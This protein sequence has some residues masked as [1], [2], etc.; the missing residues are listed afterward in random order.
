MRDQRLTR[1]HKSSKTRSSNRVDSPGRLMFGWGARLLAAVGAGAMGISLVFAQTPGPLSVSGTGGN[2]QQVSTPILG[3]GG[4][5]TY[6]QGAYRVHVFTSNGTFTPPQGLTQLDVLIVG[7]GGGGGST[8][9]GGGGAGGLRWETNVTVNQPS[10]SVVVGAGGAGGAGISSTNDPSGNGQA[11]QNSSFGT[12]I[13][14][15]GG[16]GQ[17]GAQSS[18][19][20]GSGGSGGGGGGITGGSARPGGSA[21]AGQGNVGGAGNGTSSASNRSGGGGGG[22]GAAGSVGTDGSGGNGG[23]GQNFSTQFGTGVGA[24]GWF[25]GGGGGGK[26]SGGGSGGTGGTGGGGAGGSP[27][28]NSGVAGQAN[29]GGGGGASGGTG[30]VPG[31]AGGSGVVIVRY[32]PPTNNFTVHTFNSSGTFVPPPG[33]SSVDVLVVAG[34]GGGGTSQAFGDAGAGGGGAGGLVYRTGFA[35][36]S[37]VA[38][39]VGAGGTAGVGPGHQTG[40]N[41]GNS[42]FGSLTALGGGGGFGGNGQGN[43]GGS[44]GGSRG[45]NGGAATQPGAAT[46]GSGSAGGNSGGSPAGAAATGGGGAGGAGQNLA[47]TTGEA[48][49]NGGVGLSYNISGTATFYA[50]G[51]GGGAAQNRAAGGTGGNGGGGN[52]G[53]NT[54]PATAG[55]ANRGGGGGG[56][57]NSIN[58]A[59]GGS[60]V[61]IVRYAAPSATL[62]TQPS[63]TAISGSAFNQPAVVTLLNAS[64]NPIVG[65]NVTANIETGGGTLG[66]TTTVAT[67]G[68]GQAV[69]TNLTITGAAG[70]RTLGFTVTGTNTKLIS[71]NVELISYHFEISHQTAN[72]R[73]AAFTPITISVV[74]SNDNPVTNFAGTLTLSNGSVGSYALAAGQQGSVNDVTANDGQAQVTL[75]AGNNGSIVVNFSTS[76]AQTYTFDANAGS[77]GTENYNISLALENCAFRIF[78]DGNSNVC[79]VEP[80]TIQVVTA[81]GDTVV[82]YTGTVNISTAGVTGGNWSK[83]GTASDAFGTLTPGTANTG[84]ASYTFTATDA[85]EIILNFQNNN[86]E[87]VNFNLVAANVSQP[88]GQYDP[89]LV[90]AACTFRVTHSGSSDVC[91]IEEVTLTLVDSGGNTITN[92]TGTVNLSTTTGFGTWVDIGQSDGNLVDPVDGDGNATYAFQASDNGQVV[93]GF[94]H[95]SNT[96]PVNIN[97]SDGVTLDP[98]SSSSMY[99]QNLQIALCTFE[100]THGFAANACEV[101]P[102][103]FTV[104]DSDNNIASDYLG[105]MRISNN[106]TSGNWALS[107]TAEGTIDAPSGPDT[108]I[109][110]YTFDALD[111]GQVILDFTSTNTGIVNF[112]VEDGLIVEN[113]A[114]D[115]NLFYSGCF[116]QIFDGAQCTSPGN[117]TSVS[118]P[119]TN[120]QA[121]LKSRMVLMATMQVGNSNP[122]TTATYAGAPMT[123]VIRVENDDQAPGVTTEI[124]A[125]FDDDLPANAG[126]YAGVFSG[127]VNAPAICLL[128]V[129]GVE[130]GIPIPAATPAQGPVNGN[131]YTGGNVSGRHSVAAGITTDVNNAF[132]FSIVANDAAFYNEFNTFFFRP[133]EPV[134]T[135]T[136][137][138]GGYSADGGSPPYRENTTPARPN[139]D[140]QDDDREAG[141]SAGSAGVLSSAGFLEVVEPF[142]NPGIFAPTMNAMA[143]AAFRPLV[144]GEP[145]ADDYVPVTLYETFS[146]SMSYIAMGN[147]LR[148]SGS[149]ADLQ[150][151][152]SV[153]CSF[154][155]FAVGTEAPLSLPAGSDVV[156]AYLYW[157]GSGDE[158]DAD[159]QVSFGPDGSEVAVVADQMFQAVNVTAVNAGFFA[160]YAEV[161]ELVTG[162]GDYRLKDLTVQTGGVWDDNGTCSG[163]W[164]M[165]VVYENPDERLRVLNLFHGLQPFQYSAF[166]LVPRNF[167][168]ATY[169]AAEI[170][171]NGLVTHVTMEGDEQ[172]S[173]GDESLGIQTAPNATTFNPL[174]NSFNS[175]TNEFNST[176]TRPLFAIGGTGFYEFQSSAGLNSD[177]YEIDFPG[178]DAQLSGRSGNRI[179]STWGIDID[180]HYL[181][182]TTL[183]NFS[184]LGSEAERITT[185]YSS[186]QDVVLLVSE[187]ISVTNFPIADMEVFV[188]Q[189]GNF[190]VNGS[191]SYQVNVTNNGNG[192]VSAGEATGEVTVAMRLPDGMTFDSAGDVGGTGWTCSVTLSPGAFTCTYDIA[193]TYPGGELPSGDSLPPIDLDVQIG[194]PTDFPLL[195]NNTPIVARMLHSGG[196][197][198]AEANG[199]IPDPDSCD[200]APQFDN[201]NDDQGGVVDIDDVDQKTSSNNNVDR[202]ITNIRGLETDLR[203]VKEVV[204]TLETG[205]TGQYQLVVTN[206][207]PD[208][209][210]ATITVTDSEPTG[211]DFTA[212]SGTGWVCNTVSPTLNCTYAASLALN[213]SATI[214]LDVDVVGAAGFNVTNTAQV[215]IG[216][217]NFDIVSSNNQD[218]D[219][220]TI[221]GPP[222]ASQERFLLS[223]STPGNATTIGGLGP[224]ENHDLIIYNPATDVATM[225]FDDSVVNSGRI[226][227]I[228]AVHLLKNGHLILSANTAS[229]IGSNDL[230]FEPSDLVR[231]DP[232]LDE[233]TLFLDGDTVFANPASTN[234]NGVYIMDDCDANNNNEDCTVLFTTTTGGVA[235]TNNLAFTSSD[236][237]GYYRS[238][239]NAGEAFIYLEGSDADVFGSTEGNGNVNVDAFYLRVDPNDPTG[240]IDT[241]VLSADNATATIGQGLDPV[242]GT[243]FTRD[244]VTE[245]DRTAGETQNLFVGDEELGVFEPTSADRRLD[246]LHLVEDGYIGHFQIRQDQGGS[247]CE[248]GVVRIS[249]HDGLTHD[250]DEDYYGT[251]RITTSTNYGTWQ[252]QSG[253]GT[254]TNIGNGQARYTFVSSDGGDVVLRLVHDQSA[255]VNVNVTNGI[256]TELAGSEDPNFT[257]N[258]ILTPITWLDTFTVS[259]FNNNEGSRNWSGSWT[260]VDGVSGAGT[261][262]GPGTGNIQ[263]ISASGRLRLTSSVAANNASISPSLARTFD[264]DAVPFS[265]DVILNLRYGHSALAASDSLVVEARGSSSDSWLLVN[266][267]TGLTANQ[268]NSSIPAS[269]NLSTILANGSQ[270]FSASSQIRFRVANGYELDRYFFIDRVEVATATDECGYTGTGSLDHYAI[271]HSGFGISCV[272]SPITITAHDSQND[273]IDAGG[274][275]INL[276][277]A[278]AKGTWARVLAGAGALSSIASQS[279]NGIASYTFAPGETSVT[280]L[281]NYTVPAGAVEPVNIN[282]LGTVSNKTELEDPTLQIAEAGL[283]FFNE[284]QSNEVIPYQIAGKPSN[285]NPLAQVLTLQG[286]RSSDDNPQQCV[287]LFDAGQ[288]LT[289]GMAA[290]CKDPAS[291]QAGESFS[292]NGEAI[293]LVNDNSTDGATTYTE[294]DLDFITQPSGAPG[295]TLVLNYSDVGVMQLHG[296]FDIPFGFFG[297][298]SPDNPLSA[299]GYSGD[300]MVGS[301][302]EFVV[303]PFGFA[304]DFPGDEGLDRADSLPADNFPDRNGETAD[305]FAADEDGNV[306]VHAGEGFDLVVTAMGWQA[307]DDVNQDGQPDTGANLHDNRPTPNF[308]Y[309][310]DGTSDDYRIKLTVTENQVEALGGVRGELSQ[311]ILNYNSFNNYGV[312]ATGFLNLYYNE[313]G[314]IDLQAELVDS[315]E[316]PVSYLG[317]A[318]IRGAVADVGRFYPVRF[319]VT[320]DMLLPRVDA[321][322]SPPSVF[323]YMDEPFGVEVELVARN[324]QGDPTVNYRDVF[325]KL[326]AYND[327]NFRAIEE[328]NPGDNNNLTARLANSSVP[329]NFQADWG[330]I[331]GGE[332]VLEGNLI[333][334]RANPAIPDGPFADL[335]IAMVPIDS[336]GVTLDSGDLDAEITDGDPEFFEIDRH[337]FRYGR[338]LVNN[339]YGPETEPL[340]ITFQVE[341]FDGSRFIINDDDNCT[342]I[343]AADLDLLPGTYTGNLD[344]GETAITTPQTSTFHDGRIQG[345]QAATNPTDATLEAS[346]PGEDNGGTVDVELDL[347]D[348]GLQF[349]QFRWPH[350]DVNY[351]ENPRAQLEFG[352][353]R[354][355]DRVIN[356]QELYNGPSP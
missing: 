140:T 354:S 61:V 221:V 258:E 41:G 252:L 203:I 23:V 94:R 294:I 330:D 11:G 319:E 47:G 353:F 274:E 12:L 207:G 325:A 125:I 324:V 204:N 219:I 34:G 290:E 111:A 163:G 190:K 85:G 69:F 343:N 64:G 165:I 40:G 178:P 222:V 181:S 262:T 58:G 106:I 74:D 150:V 67:N 172:L 164:S 227:D 37:S 310:S 16:Y 286:V 56:G 90:N 93:L 267:F 245:L 113:G 209:T 339:A 6:T 224:F 304:I 241:F 306:F 28:S 323:T 231:Y 246:A 347:D 5:S 232:I 15:G 276:T 288:T 281:L 255:T 237:V 63:S 179:G 161:T 7:G 134:S 53:N 332:L 154:V 341:Y 72:G 147:S 13:A 151:D 216:T 346:A 139:Q 108:G 39:T 123:R 149:R 45:A 280:L 303:R 212:A 256:A 298:P 36:G 194:S 117:S 271:S 133:S 35:V 315:N 300:L 48:G 342:S 201:R 202:V 126:S 248:A 260:E 159:S 2:V 99:D 131:T 101:T 320:S 9:G 142:E 208:A 215:S 345:V 351:N 46:T 197:C 217:G 244:D 225:F 338:L 333:F 302:E 14:Q 173:T 295:A 193:A 30:G 144:T 355:H 344:D 146:G 49:G 268:S 130:Q 50:G 21:T 340:A 211:V 218:T 82:G 192:S 308:Y 112:D 29:T 349:L 287:P 301:S 326:S 196:N 206:L 102:V 104:R 313:V 77:I 169:D 317:T 321:N 239:P 264:L 289:I 27:S 283:R 348:L 88:S 119:A 297:T 78:H 19:G 191:G 109:A 356:W 199:F 261:G 22:A 334:Q 273:P 176:V 272:G 79:S 277:I 314:I 282:V 86:V 43:S 220:T 91:S 137:L 118:I 96:G 68:S 265:E 195:N 189:S 167:R 135:L 143:V 152:P 32:I 336:D 318:V 284:T 105:T 296:E 226:N 266:N 279:D 76:V 328:S 223:V 122:S 71:N 228:N 240:V 129:T 18:A 59:A 285:V 322:C 183:F 10:Y 121:S 84:A 275:T 250:L 89:N 182:P 3:T 81:S 158:E 128:S 160:G 31:A 42:V 52:G 278:P 124:W 171:P 110:D 292:V 51:G 184:Q 20:G 55:T 95:S 33:V 291:C 299:P 270:S 73:C 107:G 305:S 80:I 233:A 331:Q 251:I 263:V 17:G 62:T 254:F 242:T 141:A 350:Q 238:G 162:S 307:G 316:D 66:G 249:K 157:M 116:P 4:N 60:G 214:T 70:V 180:T 92:Y 100:I 103:T 25:A 210:T 145:L 155:D 65:A 114:F 136:G 156:A 293:S 177:G 186:G 132:I 120:T 75:V 115:P 234:I 127:G 83:T 166:T 309:D 188:S 187:V 24:S 1:P 253:N 8:Y 337:D 97:V 26:R 148:T 174:P 44:G 87:T 327:L 138:W 230:N 335:I 243:L 38:V 185:R 57:N 257:F 269:Y 247:V 235:G 312:D 236:I 352:Q 54:T 229:T 175:S 329:A 153:D 259:A 170:L 213:A 311:D 205:Q 98:R 168:M 200:R 198:T